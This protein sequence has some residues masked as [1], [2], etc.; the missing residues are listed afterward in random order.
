[1]WPHGER[2]IHGAIYKVRPDVKAVV[3]AHP[4]PL[5]ILSVTDIP[6]RIIQ[7][8]A[9]VF[10]EGVPVYDEYD[11]KSPKSSGM[12]VKTKEEGER[13]ART[14]GK[15]RGMLMRGHGRNVV[16]QGIPHTVQAVIALRD[17][18]VMQLAA[19][20]FG[21]FKCLSYEEAKIFEKNAKR[22]LGLSA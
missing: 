6:V 14:L 13:V 9:S 18:V 4:K 7:H 2:I 8:P 11:L 16:A 3:H 20:P 12:L 19:Q 15:A 5:V 17:N 21:Q 10:Y 22:L 1:V